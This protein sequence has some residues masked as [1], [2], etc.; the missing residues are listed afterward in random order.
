MKKSLFLKVMVNILYFVIILL[1]FETKILKAETN[2]SAVKDKET[3]EIIKKAPSPDEQNP[4]IN[5]VMLLFDE[6]HALKSQSKVISKRHV[7]IKVLKEA[8]RGVGTVFI[9]FNE[10]LE[11][12]KINVAR[13]IQPNGNIQDV[14]G[15]V[16]K[17]ESPFAGLPI[18]SDIK[19]K[20]ITFP[21]VQVGSIIEYEIEYARDYN[22][23]PGYFYIF[24]IPLNWTISQVRFSVEVPKGAAVKFKAERFLNNE[25]TI[26][27]SVKSETY[28][29]QMEHTYVKGSDEPAVPNYM[30]FGPYIIFSTIEDWQKINDWGIKLMEKESRPDEAI[31][32]KVS[33]L[34]AGHKE[35]KREI[36]K[37]IF[38][39]VS[40]NIRYVAV[41][42]GISAFKPYPAS[43]VF[44]NAYGDCKG[45]SALLITMLKSIGIPAYP[46]L[47]MTANAGFILKDV[48]GLYFN[49]MIVA[50]PDGEG[51]IFLDPTADM[52]SSEKI[53]YLD[54]GCDPFILV[55]DKKED[56]GYIPIDSPENN[57]SEGE[58]ELTLKRD[59]SAEVKE[60]ITC[61][62][63]L[64]WSNRILAKYTP[65]AQHKKLFEEALRL[66]SPGLDLKEITFSD[67]NDLETPFNIKVTYTANNY[68]RKSANLLLFKAP[69]GEPIPTRLFTKVPREAPL[70]LKFPFI[71]EQRITIKLPEG[72][73]IKSAPQDLSLERATASF[74]KEFKIENKKIIIHTKW[75]LKTNEVSIGK[76]GALK[77][78]IENI[79]KSNDEDIVLEEEI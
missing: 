51:Y 55:K 77:N 72:Y 18:Y 43:E 25:P 79:R 17:D 31:E 49:H 47:L 50:V 41:E 70:Y 59:L 5:A 7:M 20:K 30:K 63:Q 34:I 60:T 29:W 36:I 6:K 42:L 3:L 19:I 32:K 4:F 61:I 40:Q 12:V 73:N 10:Y 15:D 62:G 11:K 21:N 53:P 76:Y 67:Y 24:T 26:T 16:I 48:P 57:K 74:S 28:T 65:P 22:F 1:F 2:F 23:F 13:T 35:N 33:E 58:C 68:L 78:M 38:N 39:Y 27:S 66:A 44:K 64:D 45:K 46:V 56:F 37:P 69:L 9:P 54:Q 71:K 52:L 75:V 8:G 14:S